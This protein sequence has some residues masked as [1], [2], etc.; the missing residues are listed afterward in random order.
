[1]PCDFNWPFQSINYSLDPFAPGT[2]TS[3][4]RLAWGT[5]FGF[6]GQASY[7]VHGSAYYGGPL[8]DTTAPGWPR[9]S[10]SVYV[11][12]GRHSTDP[13]GAAVA[14]VETVQSLALTA[15]LGS[16]ATSGPAGVGRA[17]AVTY[18]P[19]GYD[20]VYGALTFLA[21]GNRLDANIAVG[22]GALRHP[23]IVVRGYGGSYPS[24]VKLN[25]VPLAMDVDWFPSLRASAQELW[26]TL[27]RDL[28]GS[29][30]RLQVDP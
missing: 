19:A 11:V 6:L 8:P 22:S 2:P 1:M 28:S 25:G 21:A 15:S 12:L 27:D 3:N 10:Y 26:I 7:F 14:Q 30:N 17:D 23:V 16:V 13:V 18:Q 20:A 5:N 4:T 24:S 29:A 9:K